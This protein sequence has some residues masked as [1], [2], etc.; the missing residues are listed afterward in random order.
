M[1]IYC[2]VELESL[3]DRAFK[4][5]SFMLKKGPFLTHPLFDQNMIGSQVFEIFIEE[6]F[7]VVFFFFK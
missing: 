7:L 5:P 2:L 3:E 1:P 4:R 6:M